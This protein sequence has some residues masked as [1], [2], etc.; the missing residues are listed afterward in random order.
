MKG[1][2]VMAKRANGEGSWG[3]RVVKGNEYVV[4]TKSYA[5]KRKAF[6]GKTKAEVNKKVKG[7]ELT[8]KI[9]FAKETQKMS[10]YNYCNNWLFNWRKKNLKEKT[11]DYYE[12]LLN[13]FLKNTRLG[14]MQI[15]AI[16]SLDK[17]G[18]TRL[19][20]EHL[21]SYKKNVSKSTLD[22]LYTLLHQICKFGVNNDDFNFDY[23]L[24]VEKITEDEVEVKKIVK[25]SLEFEQISLLY[26]EMQRKNTREFRINGSEGSYVYGICAYALLFSC[27]TGMRWGEVSCLKWS[28]VDLD[29]ASIIVNKQFVVV[30][31]RDNNEYITKETSVK[32]KDSNRIIPLCDQ[33]LEILDM[34]QAR[35]EKTGSN[36]IFTTTGN[37]L[38]NKNANVTLDRMCRRAGLPHITSHELRHSFASVLLNEDEQNLYTVSKLLGHS[39]SEVTWKRY[40]HI[41]EKNKA[42][43]VSVFNKLNNK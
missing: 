7:F 34:V 29:N 8:N 28:D 15:K 31:D 16:N 18:V 27:F 9:D 17:A 41:F 11:I 39:S 1:C 43:T 26:N 35:F 20:I 30:K 22:G 37:P 19:F 14:N 2:G 38:S 4:L 10:Y 5:G 6:Y 42:N 23:M 32:S 13:N 40:I 21:H 24:N 3:K 36:L 12:M 25:K 33:A